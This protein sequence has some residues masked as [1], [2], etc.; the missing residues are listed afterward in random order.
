MTILLPILEC[1]LCY[2]MT[3]N[4]QKY[5]ILLFLSESLTPGDYDGAGEYRLAIEKFR[6]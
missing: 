2:T 3:G 4:N 1:P 6:I 5:N